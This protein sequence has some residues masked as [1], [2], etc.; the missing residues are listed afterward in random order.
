M[1]DRYLKLRILSKLEQKSQTGYELINHI[2]IETGKRPSSG[3]IYPLLSSMFED[4]LISMEEEGRKKIYSITAKGKKIMVKLLS[5]KEDSML[6]HL[7][8]VNKFNEIFSSGNSKENKL[9]SELKKNTSFLVNNIKDWIGLRDISMDLLVHPDYEKKKPLIK[10]ALKKM[11]KELE[12]IR[13][14]PI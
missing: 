13:D 1:A 11:I 14:E 9:E 10:K 7:R 3:T 12:K 6:K 4:K 8:F 2:D 5:C